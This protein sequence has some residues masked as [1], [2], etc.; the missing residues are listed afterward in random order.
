MVTPAEVEDRIPE[1]EEV[2]QVVRGLRGRRSVGMSVMQVEDLKV[3]FQ[4]ASRET[5]PVKHWWRLLVRIIYRTFAD[6]LVPDEVA[7]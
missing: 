5:K 7:W 1:E 4:E 6:G 3:R 2:A